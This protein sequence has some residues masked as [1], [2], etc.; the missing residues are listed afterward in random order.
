MFVEPNGEQE[1]TQDSNPGSLTE[2]LEPLT[3]V[4]YCKSDEQNNNVS[5]VIYANY[6]LPM[7]G[8]F[9]LFF[10][11]LESFGLIL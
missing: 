5:I 10:N 6:G 4:L 7:E 8:F 1:K 2:D 3:S 11:G 9:F